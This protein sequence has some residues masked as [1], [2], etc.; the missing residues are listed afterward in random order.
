MKRRDL[1]KSLTMVAGG[2][3]VPHES[4]AQAAKQ[5]SAKNPSVIPIRGLMRKDGTLVQ[6]VQISID[7]PGDAIMAVT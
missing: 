5:P 7:K 1:L 3:L 6:P 4:H 2:A